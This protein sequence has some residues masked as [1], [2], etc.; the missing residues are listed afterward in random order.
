M[1]FFITLGKVFITIAACAA[2]TI[3]AAYF[4]ANA[5]YYTPEK[6]VKAKTARTEFQHYHP[7]CIHYKKD[8]I[9]YWSCDKCGAWMVIIKNTVSGEHGNHPCDA[10]LRKNN[11][12]KE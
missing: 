5:K 2:I 3:P 11:L 1:K 7:A 10:V 12:F 4:L 8:G 9:E 6:I